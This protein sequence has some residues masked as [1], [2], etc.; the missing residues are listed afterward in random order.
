MPVIPRFVPYIGSINSSKI[1]SLSVSLSEAGELFCT[2]FY[3]IFLDRDSHFKSSSH[4]GG[5]VPPMN[6][7]TTENLGES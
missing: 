2:L 4:C 5:V 7:M 3:L 1:E 6:Q